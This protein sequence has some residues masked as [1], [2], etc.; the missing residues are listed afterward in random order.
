MVGA[1][2]EDVQHLV[3]Q[4]AMLRGDGDAG[5]EMLGLFAE[6]RDDR[7]QLDRLGPGAENEEDSQERGCLQRYL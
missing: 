7:R 3:K 1:D 6:A 5:S 4:T 2:G